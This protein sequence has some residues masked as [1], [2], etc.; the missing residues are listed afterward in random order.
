[1]DT[2]KKFCPECQRMV[3]VAYTQGPGHA[4]QANIPD[5]NEG[6]CLDFSPHCGDCTCPL[7]EQPGVVLG[8]RLARSGLREDSFERVTARCEGCGE[9]VE[10]EVLSASL[11]YCPGCGT[12]NNL[13][14]SGAEADPVER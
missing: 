1:M 5:S 11:A 7:F 3:T 13:P 2:E 6:V 8:A 14:A 10:M 4:S 12:T 9:T